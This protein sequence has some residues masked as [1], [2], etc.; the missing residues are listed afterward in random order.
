MKQSKHTPAPWVASEACEVSG[1]ISIKAHDE[2]YDHSTPLASVYFRGDAVNEA[3]ARLIAAAP[4]L[5]AA[6]QNV[7]PHIGA[8]YSGINRESV[9][10]PVKEAIAKARGES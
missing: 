2:R 10:K 5:L 4:E 7:M 8:G 9:L 3:N 6:L 1:W